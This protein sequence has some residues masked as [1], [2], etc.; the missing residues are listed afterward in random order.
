VEQTP[1][2]LIGRNKCPLQILECVCQERYSSVIVSLVPGK[3]IRREIASFI[4][5]LTNDKEFLKSESQYLA[6]SGKSVTVAFFNVGYSSVTHH[7]VLYIRLFYPLHFSRY[8]RTSHKTT[9]GGM[10]PPQ[11]EHLLSC[12]LNHFV[13]SHLSLEWNCRVAW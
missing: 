13:D 11:D 12:D 4:R 5:V 7:W 10:L 1:S 8:D 6:K 3:M 2:R 9:Y